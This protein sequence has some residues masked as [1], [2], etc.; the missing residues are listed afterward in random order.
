[1]GILILIIFLFFIPNKEAETG[2]NP[3]PKT[4]LEDNFTALKVHYY[5]NQHYVDSTNAVLNQ[6]HQFSKPIVGCLHSIM[7]GK[8][9]SYIPFY[10]MFDRKKGFLFSN[11]FQEIKH[12]RVIII[13]NDYYIAA[14]QNNS[15]Y[16]LSTIEQDH[17]V[18]ELIR[19]WEIKGEGGGAGTI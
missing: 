11:F 5:R 19:N 6:E 2:Q 14:D 15:I 8:V 18:K 12:V 4:F 7:Y 16:I 10:G 13:Y 9:F 1:M 17:K 3:E